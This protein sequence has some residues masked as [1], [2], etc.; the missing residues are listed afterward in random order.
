MRNRHK[1]NINDAS[2]DEDISD[3]GSSPKDDVL[4]KREGK[5]Y[6]SGS[7]HNEVLEFKSGSNGG[8]RQ[9]NHHRKEM[10]IDTYNMT[11]NSISKNNSPTNQDTLLHVKSPGRAPAN[12][13]GAF[14][15]PVEP[16]TNMIRIDELEIQ[17]FQLKSEN[18]AL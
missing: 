12:K 1:I 8:F 6:Y 14:K 17:L 5:S 15:K 4:I 9:A 13:F 16:D 10:S 18:I 11:P 2:V 7:Q 3:R